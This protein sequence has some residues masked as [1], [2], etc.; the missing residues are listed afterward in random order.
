[1]P[2]LSKFMAWA[3]SFAV[4]NPMGQAAIEKVKILKSG[5]LMD[6]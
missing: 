3:T 4:T 6:F 1:M 5:V 2:Y